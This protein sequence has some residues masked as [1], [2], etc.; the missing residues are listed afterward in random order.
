M[1]LVISTAVK[2]F[3]SSRGVRSSKTAIEALNRE[4]ENMCLKAVDTALAHNLK[5]IQAVHIPKVGTH[6]SAKSDDRS[7]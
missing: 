2:K 1:A 7:F 5:T 4:V 3:F 6:V